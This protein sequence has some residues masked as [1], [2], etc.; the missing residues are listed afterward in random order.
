MEQASLHHKSGL[1][2]ATPALMAFDEENASSMYL[3]SA[4]TCLYTYATLKQ[5]DDSVLGGES[6][7][8][9][10]I[11]LSRQSF[12]IVRMANKTLR[13]GPLGP[14]FIAGERRSGLR[15]QISYDT[16]SGAA[17]LRELSVLFGERHPDPRTKEAYSTAIDD[18]LTIFNVISTLPMEMRESSDIFG[19]PFRLTEEY[20]EL[21]QK[22]TQEALAILAYFAVLPE[23]LGTKWWLEG[24]GRH[25]F[26]KIYPLIEDENLPWIQWPLQEI[27]WS[28]DEQYPRSR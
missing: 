23:Q 18:L 2:K 19:W 15:N 10:W 14:L 3:F 5:T 12:S 22:P 20:L 25:L 24:F 17:S 6:G 13:T 9:E 7:V 26:S 27:G 1:S 28:P 4:L 21:L 8:A 16:F 11:V